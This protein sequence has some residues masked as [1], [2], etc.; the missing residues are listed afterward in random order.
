MIQ[1]GLKIYHIIQTIS[2]LLPMG[3]LHLEIKVD[4]PAKLCL[5]L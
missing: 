3:Q 5:I 4:N 2:K 1:F